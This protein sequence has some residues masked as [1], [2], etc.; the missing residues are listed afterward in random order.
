MSRN[1]YDWTQRLAPIAAA[2]QP[3]ADNQ[4]I[5][6]GE[7]CVPDERGVTRVSDMREVIRR[8]PDRLAYFVFD[9][10]WFDGVDLRSL[11][12]LE[13]KRRLRALLR[14]RR[15]FPRVLYLDHAPGRFVRALYAV[16]T[17]LGCEGIV[18]KRADAPYRSGPNSTWLKIKPEQVRQRQAESV[19]THFKSRPTRVSRGC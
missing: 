15:R 13:R 3:L 18:S 12:L 7:V 8:E 17:Q 16:A 2:L 6:D 9:L 11:P 10:L 1:R 5:L 14:S 4:A 19:R